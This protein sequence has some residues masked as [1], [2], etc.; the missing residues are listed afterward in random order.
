MWAI[1]VGSCLICQ[2]L[3]PHCAIDAKAIR[4]TMEIDWW[5]SVLSIVIVGMFT[6]AFLWLLEQFVED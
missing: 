4:R 3:L 6:F 2:Y 1:G 5:L